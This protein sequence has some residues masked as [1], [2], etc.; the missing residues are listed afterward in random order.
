MSS[1]IVAKA[2]V[3]LAFKFVISGT[4]V[5]NTLSLTYPHKKKLRGWYP[6]IVVARIS[7]HLSQ[8]TCLEML[9]PKTDEHVNPSVEVHHLV[10]KLSTAETLLTDVQR[11]VPTCPRSFLVINVCNA[12]PVLR[13]VLNRAWTVFTWICRGTSGRPCEPS[14]IT[15]FEKCWVADVLGS[16]GRTLY[17][18]MGKFDEGV[19]QRRYHLYLSP[20]SAKTEKLISPLPHSL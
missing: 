13:L 18:E 5:E 9:H 6:A 11:K 4:G 14:D 19:T 7:V 20:C 3:I 8:S 12:H 16:E 1:V 15:R 2:S 17:H 10:G